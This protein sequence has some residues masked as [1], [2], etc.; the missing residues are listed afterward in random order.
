MNNPSKLLWEEP[1]WSA[2]ASSWIDNQLS[3][4][5]INRIGAIAQVR[6]RHWSTILR[7]STNLADIY[8]KAVI[9]ELAYE[10]ALTEILS[11]WYPHCMPQILAISRENGWL[12]M[13]DGGISLNESL[14]TENDIQH[15]Q[16]ILPIYAQLQ[17]HAIAHLDQLLALGICGRRLE[18]LPHLY[19]ELLAN[20]ELLAIN[21]PEGITVSEYQSLQNSAGLFT[22]LCEQLAAFAI[23]ETIH[24][25]DLHDGN[26]FIKNG[27]YIFLDWGDSSISHPFFSIRDIYANLN[28]RFG[29][30]KKSVW[31]QRL[32]DDYLSAWTEYETRE[33]LEFAFELSQKISPIPDIC[34]WIPVLSN[35]DAVTRDNYIDA[36]PK[37]LREF[38]KNL[39]Q[40]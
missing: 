3:Q 25:G 11:H 20:T 34:R 33:K 21:H 31:F 22:S 12:L 5:N 1:I 14:K 17:K 4:Q 6:I 35:M 29:L 19:A 39:Q 9:P 10:A 7:I 8:F 24:H 23:P 26:I 37:R 38:L 2:K 15:W 36:I 40:I 18:M 27:S 30:G 32:K 13:G 28:R 16:H